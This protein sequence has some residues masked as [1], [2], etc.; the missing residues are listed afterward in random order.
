MKLKTRLFATMAIFPSLLFSSV[1]L[2]DNSCDTPYSVPQLS[3][4]SDDMRYSEEYANKGSKDIYL[5]FNTAV[6]GNF[7]IELLKDND[8]KMK[9]Q[10][11]IGNSCSTL[12]LVE[13]PSFE[14]SHNVNLPVVANRDYIIK[15]VKHSNGNSRYNIA[16]SFIADKSEIIHGHQLPPEPDPAVNNATLLGVDSN[17]NS[18]RDDVERW[19]YTT[20]K[21]K[22]PIYADIAMQAARGYT[23]VLET[24]ERAKEILEEVD[25]AIDCQ[26]YYKYSAEY[27][28][29][30]ILIQENAVDEHFRSKIYFNTK[31][32]MDA[33]IQYDNLL[34]GDT[35]TLPTD[36]EQK[37]ACNFNT[38]KYKE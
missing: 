24:P 31:E 11:F 21:D 22:H 1:E 29:D 28:G 13:K 36:K 38:S 35:Y 4:I 20:Y 32:R 12:T 19:I 23:L 18:V 10:L 34:S 30:P 15:I 25:K 3:G 8:K 33:Y 7:S 37:E 14:Y 17:N 2:A 6:D 16:Y 27:Y 5:S 26:A 9:Y